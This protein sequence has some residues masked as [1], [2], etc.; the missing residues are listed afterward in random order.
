MLKKLEDIDNIS[1]ML[2]TAKNTYKY[3]RELTAELDAN[4]N[5]FTEIHFLKIVL[6]KLNRYPEIT[7]ETISILNQLKRS[8]SEEKAK[9]CLA[10]LLKIKGCDLP[11]ASTILR[12]LLPKKFQIIDQRTY[13]IL[14]GEE[15]KLSTVT[16]KKIQ[17]YF[18]YLNK[19]AEE[20]SRF[21]IPF[22][23]ADRLLY[24]LDKMIN[25]D[26]ALKN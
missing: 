19:L 1:E 13:R 26:V 15:L 17:K 2:E 3:Q 14:Y 11:M 4:N 8:Y 9:E 24:S 22:E 18:T 12:F 25:K 21:N 7:D 23:K 6:W 10:H 5:E 16:E 20:T